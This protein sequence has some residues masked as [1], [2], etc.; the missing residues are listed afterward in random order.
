M[1]WGEGFRAGRTHP[2]PVVSDQSNAVPVPEMA[3]GH[4]SSL[5]SQ[6]PD[7]IWDRKNQLRV[8]GLG[9]AMPGGLHE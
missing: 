8:R 2:H 3:S 1:Q 7:R 4:L 9:D 6:H 5:T